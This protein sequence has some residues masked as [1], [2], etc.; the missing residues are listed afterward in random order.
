MIEIMEYATAERPKHTVTENICEKIIWLYFLCA[1]C[2]HW[3]MPLFSWV[4]YLP[5]A[6]RLLTICNDD[7]MIQLG[8]LGSEILGS[9]IE[10]KATFIKELYEC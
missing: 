4:E 1:G 3:W 7:I 10:R 6:E 9:L 8:T 2:W 5:V